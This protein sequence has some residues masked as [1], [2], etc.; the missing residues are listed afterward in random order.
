MS[1]DNPASTGGREGRGFTRKRFLAG[2]AAAGAAVGLGAGA[3]LMR[4][5]PSAA[6]TAAEK[7]TGLP[8]TSGGGGDLVL[9]NGVIHTMDGKNRSVSQAL[10]RNGRFADV[11]D[12]VPKP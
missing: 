7:D 1:D 11:G 5:S 12:V 8:S 4:P 3:G 9:V 10:I 6:A 2:G